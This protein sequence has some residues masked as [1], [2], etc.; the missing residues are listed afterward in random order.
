MHKWICKESKQKVARYIIGKEGSN[1]LILFTLYPEDHSLAKWGATI[2]KV[3][4][5]SEALNNDG[6]LIINIYPIKINS[7]SEIDHVENIQLVYRNRDIIKELFNRYN[8]TTVLAAWGN[9]VEE[10][11]FLWFELK[12]LLKRFPNN[13]K[14]ITIGELSKQGHPVFD[15]KVL[16]LS[17]MKSFVIEDYLKNHHQL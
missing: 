17:K 9:E 6:W 4:K 11:N 5:L 15:D 16:K 12:N 2:R 1:P 3:V 14:W 10:N 7:I 8:I 13:I